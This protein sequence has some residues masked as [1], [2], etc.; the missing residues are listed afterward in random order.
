MPSPGHAQA[1]AYPSQPI[2][3]IVAFPAGG[4]TDLTARLLAEQMRQSLGVQI[5]VENRS[6]ASGMIGTGAVAK[7]KPDGYTLLA[8]SGEVAVNPHLY[9]PMAYDWETDLLPVTLM[10]RVPNVLAVHPDVPA[11][12]VA[13]LIAHAKANA[14]KLTFSSSGIGN[15]QQLT[16]ELFN[17]MA[18]VRINHVPYKGAAP[19]IADVVGKHITMT[20]VSIGAALPFIDSGRL[21]ALG[22]TSTS[23]VSALPRVPPI[24]DTPGLAGFEVVNFFGMMAPAGTPPAIVRQVNTAAVQALKVPEVAAKLRESGFEPSPTTPEQFREFIRAESAK[25]GRIIVEANV[26]LEK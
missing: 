3:M 8:N 13:E 6:G 16:G 14:G 17:R 18:G 21:R 20:F 5:V 23:R 4:G 11:N 9:K 22:V 2:R 26:T 24:A 7:A 15:P 12:S 1:P 19:Q 25:F 10:V